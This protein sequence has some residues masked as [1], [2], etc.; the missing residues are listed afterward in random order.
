MRGRTTFVIAHR[1]GTIRD[2]DV[3]MVVDGG[4][5]VERGT[6]EELMQQRGIL[7]SHVHGSN[8]NGRSRSTG[9]PGDAERR[10]GPLCKYLT[11]C[12]GGRDRNHNSD[13][14]C[15]VRQQVTKIRSGVPPLRIFSVIPR[16]AQT[17]AR[18][19]LTIFR[20]FQHF[21]PM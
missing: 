15:I 12:A 13:A 20:Q 11:A 19:A 10:S 9:S 14:F 2:A 17:V 21:L 16:F 8:G 3:I 1:L 6:H 4:H 5:I 18:P 7:L